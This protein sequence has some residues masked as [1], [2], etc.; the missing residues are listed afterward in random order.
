LINILGCTLDSRS[1]NLSCGW[2]RRFVGLPTFGMN[3]L[4]VDEV[5]KLLVVIVQ[6]VLRK[7]N[8]ELLLSC[9]QLLET[10]GIV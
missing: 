7:T 4:V 8:L 9:Y 3:P 1:Q 10:K 5:A 2:R 6:P